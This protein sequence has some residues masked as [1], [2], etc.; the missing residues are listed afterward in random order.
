MLRLACGAVGLLVVGTAGYH[1]IE[2]WSFVDSFYMSVITL[3]TVGFGE[4]HPLSSAGRLFTIVF[5]LLGVGLAA[6][7]ASTIAQSLL[8][9]TW[10]RYFRRRRMIRTIEALHDHYI[11]C[12]HGRTGRAVAHFLRERSLPFVVIEL[13][14]KAA[15]DIE[16]SGETV[17][18][19]SAHD[20][21]VLLAAGIERAH[22]VVACAS[23]DAENVFICLSARS[24]RTD[25]VIVSRCDD[26][27]SESKLRKAG[28]SDVVTT[29]DLAG[30]AIA[31]AAFGRTPVR[32]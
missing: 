19:G 26:P 17:V 8:D 16:D 14:P 3:T 13:D 7:S 29:Y 25:L 24:L 27:E 5:I 10:V 22:A 12:G 23:S 2:Q 1:L 21:D 32:S 30:R 31:E 11:I 6:F 4:I 9:G 28:A 15:A 18:W 20:N